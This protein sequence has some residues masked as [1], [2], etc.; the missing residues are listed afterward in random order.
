MLHGS[1]RTP[2]PAPAACTPTRTPD[3][4]AT[5]AK[6][7]SDRPFIWT[8]VSVSPFDKVRT[9]S[10]ATLAPYPARMH[11]LYSELESGVAARRNR[12]CIRTPSM[13]IKV[14]N[15]NQG[16]K[17]QS[18][19]KM[20]IKVENASQ[21]RKCQSRSKMPLRSDAVVPSHLECQTRRVPIKV[22][23]ALDAP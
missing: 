10:L 8:F 21:G 19:S 12:R 11:T 23:I 4:L 7:R 18:R 9:A 16:R 13:P 15:A 1:A 17:C 2:A 14:E 22:E 6:N 20:P 5:R 3:L